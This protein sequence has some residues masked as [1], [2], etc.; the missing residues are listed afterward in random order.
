MTG[1][2]AILSALKEILEQQE[3]DNGETLL[4]SVVIL[5][6]PI[7]SETLFK[8]C[9][10]M[11][12][13][14]AAVIIPGELLANNGGLTAK[15]VLNILLIAENYHTDAEVVPLVRLLEKVLYALS[16]DAGG[17]LPLTGGAHLLYLNSKMESF[18]DAH[19]GWNVTLEAYCD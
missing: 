2:S 16:P 7:A 4:E 3:N 18:G 6:R 9:P 13:F 17:H 10:D 12:R 5:T 8:V 1:H 19:S 15:F 14:P 11:T